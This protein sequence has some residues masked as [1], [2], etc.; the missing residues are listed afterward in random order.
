MAMAALER[1]VSACFAESSAYCAAM[2]QSDH[3]RAGT[4]TREPVA[5]RLAMRVKLVSAA[6]VATLVAILFGWGFSVDDALIS[7]RV[8]NHIAQG[9]GH[10]FN[11]AG[12]SVDCVTPLGWAWLLAPFSGA[13]AWS[14][15][16]AARWVGVV[17]T[18]LCAAIGAWVLGRHVRRPA[19]ALV[20]CLPLLL[21][22]P[23]GAW[24]SAGMETPLVG[25]LVTLSLCPG[26]W[27]PAFAAFASAL[28]PELLPWAFTLAI[29]LPARDAKQRVLHLAIALSGCALA[30]FTRQL[31][32]GS[33][34]PLA[35][36][37]KPSD[38]SH[39]LV[40]AGFGVVQT[41]L[42]LLL[43]GTRAYRKLAEPLAAH[44]IALLAHF[45]ALVVAG[46]DW[47]A[48]YRLFV[49]VLPLCWVV[50]CA[51]L[52]VQSL[53]LRALKLAA[54]VGCSV[55]L[56]LDKGA[57]AR[58]VMAARSALVTGAKELLADRA[59]VGGLDVGWLGASGDFQIVDF[60]GLTDPDLAILP[61]G[62]TSKRLPADLLWRRKI[63][64]LVLL[65]R[66]GE[67]LE[68]IAHEGWRSTA[69]ARQVE[70]RV[71]LLDG[72]EEFA[73]VGALP[74]PNT[75]QHYLVLQRSQE[76]TARQHASNACP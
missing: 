8:A 25:L 4:P 73:L 75:T 62:H 67:D 13:G 16:L 65:T 30:A 6:L 5:L 53:R 27:G 18:L 72:A 35:V 63:D 12:P 24:A 71:T 74:L 1:W 11:S 76:R 33:V 21:C 46:G 39:G 45:G 55:W 38:F 15:L 26:L 31:L 3:V 7:T 10:R 20:Y 68:R 56:L 40:Y 42:P 41:G 37:A 59:V 28:R 9:L 44:A 69:F 66:P 36:Y 23:L 50:G 60:A 47:M 64:T 48:L 22:L 54:C 34:T 32:F 2:D 70:Q 52:D 57:S 29:L 17:C 51:L 58:G 14:G 49:P 43:L 19:W 61:G